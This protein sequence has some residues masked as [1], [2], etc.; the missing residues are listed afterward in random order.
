M[1]KGQGALRLESHLGVLHLGT[2]W[3][4]CLLWSALTASAPISVP[5]IQS[6]AEHFLSSY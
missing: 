1:G 4:F 5:A 3:E 6:L 2:Y